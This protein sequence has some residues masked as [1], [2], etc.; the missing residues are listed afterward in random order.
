MSLRR[1]QALGEAAS[2]QWDVVVIGG[3]A[4]GL[5]SAVEAA[6]RGYRT[7]LLEARDFGSGTSSRSTKLVH[8]GVRYLRQGD[9]KLVLEGL[10]ERGRILQNAPHV[11]HR[12]ALVIP[13]YHVWELPFYGAGLTL[14]DLLARGERLGRSRVLSRES[15]R[16][17]LRGVRER[18]L[19]GGILYYDGQF[20]D[21]RLA[22]ALLKTLF[23]NGGIALN[24]AP[25][26]EL[27]KRN[28]AVC[29][30]MAEDSES[31]GRFEVAARVVINATGVFT[32]EVRR[33]DEP[34]SEPLVTISQGT[35]IVLP[36]EFLPGSAAL[37]VP[38]T[39]DGRVLFAIP[40]HDRVVVGTT[41]AAV[42]GPR[43]EPEALREERRFLMSH[44][45]QYFERQPQ[46]HEVRS[47]W[48]GQRPLVRRTGVARTAALS[49]EHTILVSRSKL[50][51]ITGG[52]W[53]TYRKMGEDVIDQAAGVAG[54]P[55]VASRTAE[56]KLH[57]WTEDARGQEWEGVY[58]SDLR[59]VQAI[60]DE[61]RAMEELLHPNLPFRR[62][63]VVWAARE[64]MA[65]CVE[66]VLARRTRALFLD[67]KASREAA[68]IT[69]QLLARE[70]NRDATWEQEQVKQ[71]GG[72]AERYQC[73]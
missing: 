27:M 63:E 67:A 57:G 36:R 23:D 7:L 59:A 48:S 16:E 72:L 51:T 22:I 32:D 58:G 47:V 21:A 39:A 15:A 3:G 53:T 28:G 38:R 14:Y 18:G 52:K 73:T 68:S 12:L 25:V 34:E 71:F 4:T 54:L 55:T 10:R 46:P 13:A 56:L 9:L 29:G 35:H 69:A 19:K 31:G 6:T 60:A 50:V 30:V 45:A 41:E 1:E 33:M 42:P 26:M 20:D 24:Y 2:H 49:R 64:E 62:A 17:A 40:W 65:R 37:M 5:G 70:L 43:P 44:V 61:N 8:G 11:A 66:D